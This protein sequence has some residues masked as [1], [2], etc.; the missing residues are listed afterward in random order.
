MGFF[1]DELRSPVVVADLAAA[2]LE[3]VG[4]EETGVLNVGGR[5]VVS[6]Y[7][8][9]CLVAEAGGLTPDSIRRTSIA[10]EGLTRPR[11]CALATDRAAS[12]LRTRL[13]GA[14]EWLAGRRH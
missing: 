11:N 12:L 2:L 13:R 5:E 9:A 1:D 10:E 4:R 7:E 6:R 3:L 8:F 14:R